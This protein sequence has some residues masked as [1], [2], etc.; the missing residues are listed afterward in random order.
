MPKQKRDKA[1]D[2]WVSKREAKRMLDMAHRTLDRYI[3]AGY[4]Q[5]VTVG[6]CEK[7]EIAEIERFKR[8][9]NYRPPG[10]EKIAPPVTVGLQQRVAGI[11]KYL[12]KALNQ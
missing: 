9:G 2:R 1:L 6:N 3:A 11:P 8:E 5:T 10:S 12:R 4:I 7:V